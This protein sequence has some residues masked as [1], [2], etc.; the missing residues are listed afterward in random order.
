MSG[1][2]GYTTICIICVTVWTTY[3]LVQFFIG[4]NAQPDPQKVHYEAMVRATAAIAVRMQLSTFGCI[5]IPCPCRPWRSRVH[6]DAWRGRR[7]EE[8]SNPGP[9]KLDIHRI[10]G[11]AAT[12]S[13][14][15][16]SPGWARGVQYAKWQLNSAPRLA[17]PM[18]KTPKEALEA[19]LAKYHEAIMAS[20][21]SLVD[22][23]Q[24]E[25][26]HAQGTPPPPPLSQLPDVL[27]TPPP[28]PP[29]PTPSDL[30]SPVSQPDALTPIYS[31]SSPAEADVTMQ[32]ATTPL[33]P[34]S[35]EEASRPA[36]ESFLPLLD[37]VDIRAEVLHPVR[38]LRLV[39][40]EHS[41]TFSLKR[42][43]QATRCS[44]SAANAFCC[45][46]PSSS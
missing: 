11:V 40:T 12:L 44:S 2:Y 30:P 1:L 26:A 20:D 35:P 24:P 6:H 46:C 38:V 21:Y 3:P 39:P 7:I 22:N 15:T 23:W 17:G 4:H 37:T 27:P 18:R 14:S 25:R 33:P 29:T 36:W 34:P 28:P 31:P 32:D 45:C 13:C 10:D 42:R 5:T 9:N 8:A 43:P 19:W 16:L 41:E